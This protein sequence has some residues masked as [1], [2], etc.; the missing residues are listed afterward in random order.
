[1]PEIEAVRARFDDRDPGALWKQHR[2]PELRKS[3]RPLAQ[4]FGASPDSSPN[5]RARAWERFVRVIA[6]TLAKRHGT[7]Q[8]E[9]ETCAQTPVAAASEIGYSFGFPDIVEATCGRGHA[10]LPS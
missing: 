9:Y 2:R 5:V 4:P 1:M 10:R 7:A 8:V 3:H 6:R